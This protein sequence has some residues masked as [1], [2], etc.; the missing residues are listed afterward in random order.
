MSVNGLNPS[1]SCE[2]APSDLVSIKNPA[3]SDNS[4]DRIGCPDSTDQATLLDP[5]SDVN[6]RNFNQY[7]DTDMGV[8]VKGVA[9]CAGHPNIRI[10]YIVLIHSLCW[11]LCDWIGVDSNHNALSRGIEL[12]GTTNELGR[13]LVLH[14]VS[15]GV[16]VPKCRDLHLEGSTEMLNDRRE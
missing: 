2:S 15:L 13:N 16:P 7:A 6:L 4:L 12:R 3:M 5:G 10:T 14:L 9:V 11:E 8:E 1:W